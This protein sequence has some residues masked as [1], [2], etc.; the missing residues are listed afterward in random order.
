MPGV[1]A[2]EP[3]PFD[4]HAPL[5]DAELLAGENR[6]NGL[7]VLAFIIALVFL[8]PWAPLVAQ[9][10]AGV[11]AIPP[12][13]WAA[14]GAGVLAAFLGIVA[15]VITGRRQQ[16]GRGFAI[17]AIPIG[18]LGALVNFAFGYTTYTMVLVYTHSQAAVKVLSVTDSTFAERSASWYND[19]ASERLRAEVSLED[20]RAWLAKVVDVRGQLQKAE[21]D[22]RTMPK[23]EDTAVRVRYNGRFV[24]GGAPIDVWIGFDKGKPKVDDLKVDGSSPLDR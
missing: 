13:T 23:R 20:F 8:L 10:S 24:N 22:Q 7:A 15:V 5:S 16:R 19:M 3:Q 1:N 11:H 21:R 2:S 12:A 17:A 14:T 18:L 9:A 4:P 6:R